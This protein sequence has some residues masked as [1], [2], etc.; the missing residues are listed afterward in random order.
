M[1]TVDI[2]EDVTDWAARLLE[3]AGYSR[4]RVTLGDAEGG[5]GAQ[6]GQDQGEIPMPRHEI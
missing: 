3:Q 1:T 6:G 4:V 5:D 2:D